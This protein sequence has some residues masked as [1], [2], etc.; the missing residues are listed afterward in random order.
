MVEDVIPS[1]NAKIK[2]YQK[3]YQKE[4][5]KKNR[6]RLL[7]RQREIRES[8]DKDVYNEYAN[9]YYQ[10]NKEK[11]LQSARIKYA[12]DSIMCDV[13]KKTVN[14]KRIEKHEK[15]KMHQNKINDLAV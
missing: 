5:F 7:E 9:K 3:I 10:T 13:C 4:Y 8:R 15:T 11:I 12:E 6:D 14:K 1:K 2:E